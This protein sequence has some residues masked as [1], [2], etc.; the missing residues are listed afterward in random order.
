M[1]TEDTNANAADR[2]PGRPLSDRVSMCERALGE[3]LNAGLV[4]VH[5]GQNDPLNNVISAEDYARVFYDWSTWA[6]VGGPSGARTSTTTGSP[7]PGSVL[8]MPQI[9]AAASLDGPPA[10]PRDA[11]RPMCVPW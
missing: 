5:R 8:S 10:R 9:A 2:D 7:R 3:L 6:P 4:T 11:R 1:V